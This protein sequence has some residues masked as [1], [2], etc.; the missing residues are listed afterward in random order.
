MKKIKF[1][2][3][4]RHYDSTNCAVPRFRAT[5]MKSA[6][7]IALDVKEAKF[8]LLPTFQDANGSMG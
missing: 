3:G 1:D 6:I 7:I 2:L 4:F 5:K 8:F